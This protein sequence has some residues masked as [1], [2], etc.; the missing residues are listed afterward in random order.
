MSRQ[1]KIPCTPPLHLLTIS[2]RDG[3]WEQK[4]EPLRSHPITT[5]F[6][7]VDR[8]VI[9]E[10]IRGHEAPLLQALSIEPQGS[11][12]KLPGRE[13]SKRRAC[14]FYDRKKCLLLSPK[15]PWCFMPEGLVI[16]EELEHLV[17]EVIS[18][19]KKEVYVAVV[20]EYG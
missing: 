16:S 8:L 6:S 15:M 3:K 4:W 13:C 19:W 14:P 9:D 20:K 11:L 12:R 5:L 18:E 10:A 1:I 2:E 17:T 7:Y